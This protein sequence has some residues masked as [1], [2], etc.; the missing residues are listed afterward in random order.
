MRNGW[1]AVVAS[2]ALAVGLSAGGWFV[3]HG[4]VKARTGDRY[5]TV[6]GVAERAV[7]ADLVLWPLRFVATGNNLAQVQAKI[8]AD[9]KALT[10]FLE[11]GGTR[12]E[13]MQ[14]QDLQVTDL[15]A[16]AYRSGPVESRFIVS[17]TLLVRSTD[18]ARIEALSQRVGELVTAGIV[19][20]SEQVAGPFFAF[21]KLNEVKPQMIAEATRNARQGAEQFA[22]D[23]NSRIGGIRTANQG[24]FQILAQD[25]TPG[26]DQNKQI[27][28]TVR[29]VSTVEY[30][31][32]D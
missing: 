26:L 1:A 22:A 25:D 8:E 24:V 18:V 31:L 7:K 21:T 30:F 15:L 27:N 4:V 3:G 29:V 20:S 16:Q 13:E 9:T 14:L 5:V 17:R 11:S 10:R 2:V 23:S 32:E 6:K 12:P 19:L 28:K